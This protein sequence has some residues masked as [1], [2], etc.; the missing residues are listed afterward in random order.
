[1]LDENTI[2]VWLKSFIRDFFLHYTS[3]LL[4]SSPESRVETCGL[5]QIVMFCL[6]LFNIKHYCPSLKV[7]ACCTVFLFTAKFSAELSVPKCDDH[8][9]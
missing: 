3:R 9:M 6:S 1:M 5:C 4:A 7:F 8:K 2:M